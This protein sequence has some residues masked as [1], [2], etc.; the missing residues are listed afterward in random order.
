MQA[1]R[2]INLLY[3]QLKR[4][5][6]SSDGDLYAISV[7]ASHN[8]ERLVSVTTYE[9]AETIAA[10][11]TAPSLIGNSTTA[12]IDLKISIIGI[13][14]KITCRNMHSM[15]LSYVSTPDS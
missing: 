1:D 3:K 15:G 2:W 6:Y 4:H 13:R 10:D 12:L 9:L 8:S 11:Q 7:N 5:S 14:N